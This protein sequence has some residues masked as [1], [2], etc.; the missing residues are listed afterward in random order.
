MVD[1]QVEVETPRGEWLAFILRH[2]QEPGA[3]MVAF[4]RKH[5]PD[6]PDEQACVNTLKREA[7]R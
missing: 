1:G 7:D 6:F 2:G 5:R 3:A 4:C